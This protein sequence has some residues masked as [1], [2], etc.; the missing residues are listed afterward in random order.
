MIKDAIRW[1]ESLGY[2]VVESHLGTKTGADAIF[3]NHFGEKAILEIVTG[4]S[5]KNLFEKPRIKD[6]LRSYAL[7]ILGLVVVGDRID[8]LKN[9]GVEAGLSSDLFESGNK[10]QKVFGVRALDFKDVI[11]VLLVSILGARASAYARAGPG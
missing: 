10:R 1:A 6:A 9:H 3:Q 11:P 7:H 4:S 2:E 5:F 8:N